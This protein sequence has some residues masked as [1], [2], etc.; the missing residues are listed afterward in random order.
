MLGGIG[1]SRREAPANSRAPDGDGRTLGWVTSDGAASQLRFDAPSRGDWE[2]LLRRSLRGDSP[3]TLVGRT[4]D[5]LEIQPLYAAAD[6]P[7]S[8]DPAGMPG[9][10]PFTRGAH[11]G[12]RRW[13]LR[14]CHDLTDPVSTA[15]AIR[16]DVAGGADSV[17]LR[18]LRPPA[19][20]ELLAALSGVNPGQSPV[21]VDGGPWLGDA[22]E[23]VEAL[24][25][26]LPPSGLIVAA[27]PLGALARHGFLLAEPAA[28][29]GG[30]VPQVSAAARRSGD[31]T[32]PPVPG[33]RAITVDA[34]VYADAGAP[35]VL[36]LACALAT[37]VAY[38]RA[39][40]AGGI[41][42]AQ[43]SQHIEARLA[44]TADQF[45]TICKFRAA[46]TLWDGVLD[47]CGVG[48]TR[49]RALRCWA[50]T[51]EAM[52]VAED[53]F[54]NLVRATTASFAA[55]AGG[56]ECLTVLPHDTALGSGSE[57]GRRLARNVA[58]LLA[59]ESH[60]GAVADPAGGSWYAEER[61]ARLAG[62]A[63]ERFRE[64]EAAGGMAAVLLDGSLASEIHEAAGAR[65]E[66][67]VNG[68]EHVVGV[69]CFAPPPDAAEP[70]SR[71]VPGPP[72]GVAAPPDAAAR[73]EPLPV[74]RPGVEVAS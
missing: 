52:L 66:R 30:L 28:A 15:A 8:G 6:S 47:A 13:E 9:V 12:P 22:T 70:A 32:P 48:A 58:H 45:A 69:T 39:L 26:A 43:A 17:W 37:G 1:A 55:S 5:G 72:A 68:A 2:D 42:P 53:P 7:T 23:A 3:D 63:W 57:R 24:A 73:I 36:E 19:P 62:A 11:S 49:R 18:L 25:T 64:I 34:A 41:G 21:I 16:S 46:R 54:V 67:L 33:G 20:G 27:D 10:A 4:P 31:A 60:L 59:D 61:T 14:Q 40:E 74:R 50:V 44:A 56:A 35:P 29:L 65:R 51:S 71:G 38:L